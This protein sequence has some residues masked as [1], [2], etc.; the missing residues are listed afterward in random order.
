M[1]SG[2]VKVKCAI[3][4]D[5]G[6]E[7]FG[8]LICRMLPDEWRPHVTVSAYS[9][10]TDVI[11]MVRN[12][13]PAL[14]VIHANLLLVKPENGMKDCAVISPNTRYM[15]L[16]AWPEKET[17]PLLKFYEP[18]HISVLRMPFERSELIAAL[19]GA[20]GL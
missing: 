8:E 10:W 16:T 4:I 17:T 9:Q 12:A 15:W 2:K 3:A 5:S 1:A 18:L 6:N 11:E 13:L 14:L 7:C 19:E 20:H